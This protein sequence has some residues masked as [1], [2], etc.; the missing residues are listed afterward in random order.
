MLDTDPGR[1]RIHAAAVKLVLRAGQS[2]SRPVGLPWL[3][4]RGTRRSDSM[5][6]GWQCLVDPHP[7][8]AVVFSIGRPR[9]DLH[10]DDMLALTKLME[11]VGEAAK[12]VGPRPAGQGQRTRLGVV[13]SSS[14]WMAVVRDSTPRLSRARVRTRVL[15]S[16]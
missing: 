3:D 2:R 6:A 4:I 7:A 9:E 10:H 1:D 12:Q 16:R 13:E 15:R 8:R 11:T 14:T 5:R